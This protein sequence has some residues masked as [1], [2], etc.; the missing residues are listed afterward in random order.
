MEMIM[1]L[2]FD[3]DEEVGASAPARH[4]R[5]LAALV[6][7]K[8]AVAMLLRYADEFDAASRRRRPGRDPCRP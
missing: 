4:C 2:A 5:E 8:R 3:L 7:N 6:K 1:A